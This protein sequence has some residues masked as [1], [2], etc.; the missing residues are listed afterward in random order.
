MY[1]SITLVGN[2]VADP[3]MKFVGQNNTPIVETR[4][5]V[6]VGYGKSEKT[7]WF[8]LSE[9]G[10]YNSDG[11][12]VSKLMR[13]SRT[14]TPLFRQGSSVVITG[15]INNVGAYV[16]K[17]DGQPKA[18]VVIQVLNIDYTPGAKGKSDSNKENN[19]SQGQSSTGSD[20]DYGEIPI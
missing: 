16:S 18:D 19:T 10:T 7:L 17:A 8:K 15:Y 3:Q 5:A 4:L 13:E 6:N 14:G 9:W 20:D 2:I 12:V 11:G 1:P